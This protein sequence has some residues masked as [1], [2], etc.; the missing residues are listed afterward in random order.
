MSVAD[1]VPGRPAPQSLVRRLLS[2]RGATLLGRNSVVSIFVFAF[3]L[4]L[5]WLLVELVMLGKLTAA[6]LAFALANALHFALAKIWVFKGSERALGAGLF[7]FFV[8]AAVG[9]VITIALFAL[10]MHVTDLHYLAA[11]LITSV[12]AGLAVFAL[13]A[14]LNFRSI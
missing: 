5:L 10:L 12:F 9:L 6:G 8:N 13:N 3:D 14:V 11:R 4:A 1:A 2:R 7:Y